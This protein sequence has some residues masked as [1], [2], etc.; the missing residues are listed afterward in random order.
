RGLTIWGGS[1]LD[2]SARN[3]M[4][5]ALGISV[6]SG[7]LKSLGVA[8]AEGIGESHD[9]SP[10]VALALAGIAAEDPPV[11]FLHSRMAPPKKQV[12][13]PRTVLIVGGVVAL[14]GLFV[15]A[16]VLQSGQ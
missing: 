8:V 13:K 7:D 16:Y 2:L 5:D 3:S 14:V 12:V 15:V 4:A 9:Y 11:D 6:E 10:A 1:A